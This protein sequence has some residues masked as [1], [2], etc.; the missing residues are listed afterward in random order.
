MPVGQNSRCHPLRHP[1]A[2]TD[3]RHAQKRLVYAR[4][5]MVVEMVAPY[6]ARFSI[7]SHDLF[8]CLHPVPLKIESSG[9]GRKGK[10]VVRRASLTGGFAHACVKK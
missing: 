7:Y 3:R 8:G 6:V 1:V 2:S 5:R 4:A 10:R 9:G